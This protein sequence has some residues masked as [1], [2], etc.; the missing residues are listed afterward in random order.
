MRYAVY[1]WPIFEKKLVP[2]SPVFKDWVLKMARQLAND[3][4]RGK[5]IRF[6]YFR[7][8]K[9]EGERIYYFISDSMHTIYFVNMSGKKD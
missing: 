2:K 1:F 8:K 5:P 9:L 4:Y 6:P 3:P 7:E